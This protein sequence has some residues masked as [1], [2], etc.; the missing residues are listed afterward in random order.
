VSLPPEPQRT[1]LE[2]ELDERKRQRET[3]D[4]RYDEALTA[5]DAALWSTP[6]FPHPPPPLDETQVT[7]INSRWEI[8]RARPAV[9]SGWRGRLVQLVWTVVEPLFAGQQAFNAAVVDH[10]NR[11]IH[12]QRETAKAIASTISTLQQQVERLTAFHSL[13]MQYLQRITPFV[14]AKDYEFY[15]LDRRRH[16]DVQQL[17]YS[18]NMSLRGLT[19]AMQGISDE[20]LKH[21]ESL[22]VRVQRYDGRIESAAAAT[23]VAQQ[24]LTSLKRT[25]DRLDRGAQTGATDP[26][27]GAAQPP[28]RPSS[29]A[30]PGAS[31]STLAGDS[32]AE[33]WKYPAF[34]AAYRGSEDDIRSRLEGYV[35]IFQGA[36]DVIDL[37]C[38]RG[39]FLALLSE[40]GI[41]AQGLD[42]N[43]EMVEMC[44]GRGLTVSHGD[45]LGHLRRAGDETL[46]G[47]FAAQVAE[48]LT[49]DYL[50]ALLNE[51]QRVLRPNAALVLETI[52]VSCWYAF[53]QS[54]IR[55]I[56][57][58]RPLHPETLQYLVTASGFA[59]ATIHYRVPVAEAEKLKR[60][61][62]FVR[63]GPHGE[64]PALLELADIVDKNVD[65]LNSL[66]F[67]Y[68][69]YAIV[70]RKP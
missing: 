37:G 70:A 12:P 28:S 2:D 43:H 69:D 27:R 3:A 55:D 39:E 1:I 34:E 5:L 30:L 64:Q 62:A 31:T 26:V 15:T 51:C 66:L 17:I 46:G 19:A 38:G 14:N 47:I 57:H 44:R 4:S 10:L 25:V 50:L 13:L 33:S 53:F 56:T 60:A 54:Y 20:F 67:T 22:S 40:H 23:A 11:N 9:P 52:N 32:T 59:D 24:H 65:T 61:P 63:H 41:S 8:L 36:R 42:L 18:L 45:A 48:H 29:E 49:P 16:E 21:I 68:L 7:P 35:P 6:D 58:A